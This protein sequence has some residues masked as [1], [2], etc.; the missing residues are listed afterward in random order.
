MKMTPYA[1]VQYYVELIKGI[2]N[3]AK[4]ALKDYPDLSFAIM[5]IS[6]LSGMTPTIFLFDISILQTI[7]IAIIIVAIVIITCI[8]LHGFQ[9]RGKARKREDSENSIIA[10]D[11][12][13]NVEV[14]NR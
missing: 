10:I 8:A 6:L 1:K 14:Q 2:I 13:F 11:R 3:W 4:E 9:E 5:V 7:V 12:S